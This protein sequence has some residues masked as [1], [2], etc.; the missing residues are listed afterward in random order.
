MGVKQKLA[1]SM[2]DRAGEF[3]QEIAGQQAGGGSSAMGRLGVSM[4]P[5]VS[6]NHRAVKEKWP[7]KSNAKHRMEWDPTVVK[8]QCLSVT[9]SP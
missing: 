9:L 5:I 6:F 2:A 7:H 1:G 3:G 8:G 4:L